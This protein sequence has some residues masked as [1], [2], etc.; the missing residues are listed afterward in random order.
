V[1][2]SVQILEQTI[3]DCKVD[4]GHMNGLNS[5]WMFSSEDC[6]VKCEVEVAWQRTHNVV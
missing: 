2:K 5:H 3:S 4:I 6:R 1:K